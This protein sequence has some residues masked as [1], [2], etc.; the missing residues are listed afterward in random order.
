MPDHLL[1][2]TSSFEFT[3][4]SSRGA[5][6]VAT[7]SA[8]LVE[9]VDHTKLRDYIIQHAELIYAHA[10]KIRRISDDVP[11]YI[12]T[13]CIKSDSWALAAFKTTELS[14]NDIMYLKNVTLQGD[15]T[16]KYDWVASPTSGQAKFGSSDEPGLKNQTPFLRGFK[17]DFSP[18]FRSRRKSSSSSGK[19]QPNGEAPDNSDSPGPAYSEG[20]KEWDRTG[21]F[22]MGGNN[23]GQSDPSES[24]GPAPSSAGSNMDSMGRSHSSAYD[25]LQGRRAN[26]EVFPISPN[27]VGSRSFSSKGGILMGLLDMSPL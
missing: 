23:G 22:R 11:L 20:S 17:L 2:V 8:K 19:V 26:I 12:V 18:A 7:S 10:N 9:L 27:D 24:G 5:V 25:S 16:P 21:E 6:Y 1:R 4:R 13:G 3:C 15:N 14:H